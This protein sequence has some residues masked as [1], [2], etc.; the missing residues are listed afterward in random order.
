MHTHAGSVTLASDLLTSGSTHTERLTVM[1]CMSTK[2]VLLARVGFLLKRGHSDRNTVKR[3]Q[4]PLITLPTGTARLLLALVT[5]I[6]L[7]V[8]KGLPSLPARGHQRR[9]L[10][11]ANNTGV[12]VWSSGNPLTNQFAVLGFFYRVVNHA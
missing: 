7:S 4:T 10:A 1:H 11:F 9:H 8:V 6:L 12:L 5:T 3:S 2:L